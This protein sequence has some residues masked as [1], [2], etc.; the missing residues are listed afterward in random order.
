MLKLKRKSTTH[1]NPIPILLVE[2]APRDIVIG[3][4][5]MK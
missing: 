3:K 2:A 5:P 4:A 1:Y